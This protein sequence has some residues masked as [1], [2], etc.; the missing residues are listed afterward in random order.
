M[1]KTKVVRRLTISFLLGK[2][3][4]L[5]TP[6]QSEWAKSHSILLFCTDMK[7]QAV[8]FRTYELCVTTAA[9]ALPR[10]PLLLPPPPPAPR[11]PFAWWL[12]RPQLPCRRPPPLHKTD[13]PVPRSRAALGPASGGQGKERTLPPPAH[14][15]PP[16]PWC[17]QQRWPPNAGPLAA[18]RPPAPPVEAQAA[19]PPER[20]R[21]RPQPHLFHPSRLPTASRPPSAARQAY[22]I[23]GWWQRWG[24][25]RW[26]QSPST[27]PPPLPPTATERILA[28]SQTR[29]T[30]PLPPQR[31]RAPARRRPWRR[32]P[33]HWR[34]RVRT[35]RPPRGRRPCRPLGAPA[36]AVVA[37]LR[38]PA[39]S[40]PAGHLPSAARRRA[41]RGGWWPGWWRRKPR[42]GPCWWGGACRGV[43]RL[44]CP[45]APRRHGATHHWP[46]RCG[47]VAIGCWRGGCRRYV[48]TPPRPARRRPPTV[49]C[50]TLLGSRRQRWGWR[51][52]R[53]FPPDRLSEP[54]P[55]DTRPHTPRPRRA[56]PQPPHQPPGP[57]VGRRRR[58]GRSWARRRLHAD[59]Q[60]R[61]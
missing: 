37:T 39:P 60:R 5:I 14:P 33:Q 35:R 22:S 47:P 1:P 56:R 54:P 12:A 3:T 36:G 48:P 23:R 18:P 7:P 11:I 34:R 61:A 42:G 10:C 24:R 21:R 28:C 17:N 8:P 53:R 30:P 41:R 50:T 51:R 45:T 46:R 38:R 58:R 6:T 52:R 20:P 19:A 4:L 27:R 40:P 44:G 43:A 15:P 49:R 9:A 31:P 13:A 29:K 59:S 25:R 16:M 32:G 57:P 26:Q 2:V 55:T